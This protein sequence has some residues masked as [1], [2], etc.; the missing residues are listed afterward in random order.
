[1][2][3]VEPQTR[4]KNLGLFSPGHWPVH[5]FAYK[6][7]H[8]SPPGT[9]VLQCLW[10]SPTIPGTELIALESISVLRLIGSNF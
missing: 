5:E 6:P 3:R 7:P 1:M 4:D 8:P 2:K 9:D 10:H